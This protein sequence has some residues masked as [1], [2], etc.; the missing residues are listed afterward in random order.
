MNC[1]RTKR[2]CLGY[3]DLTDAMFL[4]ETNNVIQKARTPRSREITATPTPPAAPVSLTIR[5]PGQARPGIPQHLEHPQGLDAHAIAYYY[6]HIALKRSEAKWATRVSSRDA[7]FYSVLALG[8][9][10]LAQSSSRREVRA[11]ARVSSETA[12]LEA[13]Q[14]VKSALMRPQEAD[15]DGTLLAVHL[16][17]LYE[18]T[19][20]RRRKVELEASVSAWSNHIQG[21]AALIEARRDAGADVQVSI[22]FFPQTVMLLSMDCIRRGVPLPKNI[23]RMYK[24]VAQHASRS[25]TPVLQRWDLVVD[26]CNFYG[27]TRANP[28]CPYQDILDEAQVLDTRARTWFE[29]AEH[30]LLYS[31]IPIASKA[32]HDGLELPAYHYRY[33]SFDAAERWNGYR[34]I[35]ILLNQMI[36]SV[37]L[38]GMSQRPPLFRGSTYAQLLQSSTD[39][40]QTLQDD[41]I[42]SLP[43]Y[44][45]LEQWA[46]SEVSAGASEDNSAISP[47]SAQSSGAPFRPSFLWASW[48]NA[49][50]EQRRKYSSFDTPKSTN[51]DMP[52]DV[53]STTSTP[54]PQSPNSAQRQMITSVSPPFV[55][56]G[57]GSSLPWVLFTLATTDIASDALKRWLSMQLE[58]I[59]SK[60]SMRQALYLAL[61]IERRDFNVAWW[62]TRSTRP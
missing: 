44:I 60:M 59:G 16:M 42:S 43:Q 4:D 10:G 5:G 40:L 8:Y 51:A 21:A 17:A 20:Q 35:R 31:V 54:S 12:Y 47:G 22:R 38:L 48:R 57:G 26:F 41:V 6:R 34:A 55:K 36:R 50:D 49:D 24:Q 39:N 14:A 56:I 9:S 62:R 23:T 19:A 53:L 30:S 27:E 32:R 58:Y 33:Q 1:V 37:L 45:G 61:Q 18:T 25:E 28:D 52:Q 2:E 7:L 29:H 46:A 11:Q 3:R 13:V 15:I